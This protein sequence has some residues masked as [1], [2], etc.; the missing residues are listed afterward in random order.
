MGGKHSK[1]SAAEPFSKKPTVFQ[2]T[3]KILDKIEQENSKEG[4]LRSMSVSVK[5][6]PAQYSK[7]EYNSVSPAD[8]RGSHDDPNYQLQHALN[9]T[10]P[11]TQ[12]AG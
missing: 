3:Q 4:R 7:L 12:G 11:S 6:S 10:F 5:K 2:K 1:V 8:L 9:D